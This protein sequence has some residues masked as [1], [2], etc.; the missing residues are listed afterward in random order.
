MDAA[1]ALD[2]A[3]GDRVTG[4]QLSWAEC[5]RGW[6][7][8]MPYNSLDVLVGRVLF[9]IQATAASS[10]GY[11]TWNVAHFGHDAFMAGVLSQPEDES[12]GTW[13]ATAF[14]T[15]RDGID[16][17]IAEL[18][19]LADRRDGRVPWAERPSTCPIL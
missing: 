4:A 19:A 1:V 8:W 10:T 5:D 12:R 17:V 16:S 13:L 3:F 18:R 2:R 7:P 15:P 9:R 6:R 14:W 11:R